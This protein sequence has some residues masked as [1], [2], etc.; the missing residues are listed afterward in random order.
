[1]SIDHRP[2]VESLLSNLHAP[3]SEYLFANLFLFREVHD[4]RLKWEP[5]PHILGLTYDGARHAMPLIVPGVADIERLLDCAGLDAGRIDV[6][7][8]QDHLPA[9]A[10]SREPAD[11]V[12]SGVTDVLSAGGGWGKA[13]CR[14]R[15]SRRGNH[16][17]YL[18]RLHVPVHPP[19]I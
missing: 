14:L 3:L 8:A 2:V 4:Y 13:I 11:E 17:L 19:A 18:N 10:S 12:G 15:L 16:D 9:A 5:C 1:M 6:F 7:D